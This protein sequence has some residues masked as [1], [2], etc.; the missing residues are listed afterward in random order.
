[1]TEDHAVDAVEDGGGGVIPSAP[2]GL[3]P[4]PRHLNI[5]RLE[6]GAGRL[7]GHKRP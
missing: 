1:V 3:C 7:L 6:E 2:E 4:R 5:E